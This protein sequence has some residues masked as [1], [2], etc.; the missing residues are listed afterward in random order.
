MATTPH[1]DR[2]SDDLDVVAL[3]RAAKLR[4]TRQRR[5]LAE[6]LLGQ[7][8]RHVTAEILHEEARDAGVKVSLATVYNTLH[9]F[10]DTGLLRELVVDSGRAYF[11][12]NTAHHHHFFDEDTGKL[13]DIPGQ[14]VVLGEL[15]RTPEGQ[16]ISRVDVIVR[17]R[18]R[19]G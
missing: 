16:H 8:Q 3:L 10:T 19:R 5:A 17:V 9:Q 13:T 14:S 2:R 12:T 18:G 11:D 1:N 7:G 4:P 6:L 15:P